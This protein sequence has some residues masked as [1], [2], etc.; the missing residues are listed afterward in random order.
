[1]RDCACGKPVRLRALPVRVNRSKGVV[2]WIEHA[3]GSRGVPD[4]WK[5]SAMKPYP[6]READKEY[7]KLIA[8]WEGGL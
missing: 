6:T 4:E 5:C 7:A 1:M 2:H 8:R 3:D